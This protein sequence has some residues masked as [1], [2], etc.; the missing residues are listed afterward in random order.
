MRRIR[1]R[2][3]MSVG[4]SLLA[5]FALMGLSAPAEAQLRVGYINSQAILQEAPGAQE[6]QA[7]FEQDIQQ[8][9][10]EVEAMGAEVQRLMDQFEQQ[11]STLS[12]QARETRQQEILQRQQAFQTRVEEMEGE[13]AQ[14]QAE[15]VEPIMERITATIETI[16]AEG[17][18]ALI[19][20]VSAGS[21]I[22]A[23]PA[24]DLTA[25]VLRRLQQD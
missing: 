14:L 3:F 11:Q 6:A 17:N 5:M 15:L 18:Y 8:Y 2:R 24:L 10:Q 22:A 1:M 25:E 7:Q 16:R 21:I 19:F 9:Q 4:L 20:D 23:D 13:A 12:A